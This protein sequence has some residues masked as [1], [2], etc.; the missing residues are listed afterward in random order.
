MREARVCA[1][2]DGISFS[3]N[4]IFFALISNT[5][6]DL[7]RCICFVWDAMSY[8]VR[9]GKTI[10]GRP[11]QCVQMVCA[12]LSNRFSTLRKLIKNWI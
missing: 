12:F 3:V 1:N 4:T 5:G 7:Q 6:V 8:I 10:F 11:L 9:I 2:S